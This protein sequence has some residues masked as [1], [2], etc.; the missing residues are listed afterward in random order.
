MKQTLHVFR[1]GMGTL[2][3]RSG[4]SL[5][6][7]ISMACITAV[8]LATLSVASGMMNGAL[9]AADPT[10]VIVLPADMSREYSEKLEK[11]LIGTILD[12][13]GIAKGADGR[14]LGDA[15]TNMAV[16]PD[17]R[18][19]GQGYFR[20]RGVGPAGIELRPELKIVEGRWFQPGRQEIA[21]GAAVSRTYGLKVG[22][23]LS[24]PNGRWPIVGVFSGSGVAESEL[25]ADADTIMSSMRRTG[26]GSVLVRLESPAAFDT[27]KHWLTTNPALRVSAETQE[28]YNRRTTKDETAFF[29]AVAWLTGG[30]MSLG[31]LFGAVNVMYAVVAARTREMGM[32]RALGYDAAPVAA[33]IVL[34]MLVLCVAGALLGASLAWLLFDGHQIERSGTLY[35]TSVSAPL[36]ALGVGWAVV[37]ALLGSLLPAIRAGRLPVVEALRVV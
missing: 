34:E 2:R 19:P 23:R 20:L 18:R 25:L 33:S 21:V 16:P 30:I 22:G 29:I 28:S 17:D 24:M 1:L 6:I 8:L 4:S 3:D 12:A 31:A 7:V 37:L 13:P 32:L 36:L 11:S 14:P 27:F 5:A 9:A 26:F 15:E 35:V 10:R